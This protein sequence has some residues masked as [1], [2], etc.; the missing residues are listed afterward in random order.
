M[1]RIFIATLLLIMITVTQTN[2]SIDQVLYVGQTKVFPGD[3]VVSLQDIKFRLWGPSTM[4]VVDGTPYT[5]NRF[6]FH[7]EEICVGGY[8]Y[9]VIPHLPKSFVEFTFVGLCN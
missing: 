6:Y 1:T 2:A 7:D 9:V 4:L 3:S 8:R 5:R